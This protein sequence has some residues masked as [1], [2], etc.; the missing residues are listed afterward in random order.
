[1]AN[2]YI[3]THTHTHTHTHKAQEARRDT[4]KPLIWKNNEKTVFDQ[5]FMTCW[6]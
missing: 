3:H 6:S 4:L 2:I 1:M 5:S